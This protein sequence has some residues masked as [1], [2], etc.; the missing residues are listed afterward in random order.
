VLEKG[1][2]A[3]TILVIFTNTLFAIRFCAPSAN[4][5]LSAIFWCQSTEVWKMSRMKKFAGGAFIKAIA[6]IG[7]NVSLVGAKRPRK[8]DKRRKSSTKEGNFAD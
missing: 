8:F 2:I 5:F 6:F 1:L 3:M 7:T 4:F